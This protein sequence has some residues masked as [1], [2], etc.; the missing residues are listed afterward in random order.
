MAG[1]AR[2]DPEKTMPPPTPSPAAKADPEKAMPTPTPSPAAKAEPEPDERVFRCIVNPS[3]VVV[4]L[5]R[6]P[7]HEKVRLDLFRQSKPPDV[8][9]DKWWRDAT[10][11][12]EVSYI[13]STG[14]C[15]TKAQRE[16]WE[17]RR[18]KPA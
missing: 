10:P 17:A 8:P 16:A 9:P 6:N 12:E 2:P 7:A 4:A 13:E 3:G 5:N 1:L 15:H 18:K 14:H 11:A